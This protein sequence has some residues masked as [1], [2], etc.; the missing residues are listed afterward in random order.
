MP[1]S[2]ERIAGA[3]YGLLI[4]DALGVPYEF[5]PPEAI[6][7]KE[8]IEFMPP[9]RYDRAHAGV[10]PGTWSD[11]GAQALVLLA[12]LLDCGRFDAEDFGQGLV[13]WYDEG[14]MAVDGK[15]FDVGIQT[16]SSIRA[17][18]R[19]TS[20]LEAGGTDEYSNGNG[21]LMRVMPLALWHC[22]TDAQLVADAHAQS[23][24]THGHPRSQMCCA[25]YCLWAR[26]I[27]QE[28]PQ[29]WGD[30]LTTLQSLY[31]DDSV[32]R[33]ELD[34]H[35]RPFNE[36]EVTGSGYVIDCLR[37]ALWASNQGGFEDALKAAIA[38][39]RDTD[40][41]GCVTGGIVGLRE[42]V[43]AIPSRW[44]TGLLGKDLFKDRLGQLLL[45][46]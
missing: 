1:T 42:G 44:R 36:S 16:S 13:A 18:R 34:Y 21:S 9:R 12:S 5:R 29:P 4:G 46:F 37:S 24:V 26:R 39:G 8:Q 14:Y 45:R 41:T 22:G 19:G 10:P 43:D 20:A 38:L 28:H 7:P 3:L 2:K 40:T 11:D 27:F 35:I 15:V 25:L 6:P 33:K 31:G 30:A 17:L 32:Y 23:R